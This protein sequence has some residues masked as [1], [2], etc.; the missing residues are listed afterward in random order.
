MNLHLMTILLA[1][2]CY[3]GLIYIVLH[4]G[5]RGNRLNQVFSLYLLTMVL[6]H[7]AYLMVDI[8]DSVEG[9]LFWYKVVA[10]VVSGQ[11]IVYFIFT[12]TLLRIEV[13]S[14]LVQ[15]GLLV[16]ALTVI[17][18]AVL[19]EPAF[20][21]GIHRDEAT[22]FFVPTFGPLMPILG[23]PNY[24][25]LGYAIFKLI[26]G[27][28]GTR[29][30]IQRS[31]IQYLLLGIMVVVLGI[32]ANFVPS[33]QPYPIDVVA[34][35][36]NAL[37]ITYAI[38]RYQLLDI[39]VVVRRGLLYSIPTAIIGAGYFLIISFTIGLFHAF[40]GPQILLVSFLVAVIAAVVV[41]P[42]RDR[43]QLWIDRIFFREKYDS[44][45][46]LQRLSRTAASLLDLD[47]L[48]TMILDEVTTTMHI[49]TAAFFLKRE[50]TGEF[51]LM[52]QRGLDQ[53]AGLRLKKGHPIVD[54][55][56]GHESAL[57]RHDME[58]MPQ[59]KALWGE[60]REDLERMGAELFIPL[61]AKDELV[62][63][64]TMG[65]KLSEAA[66]SKDDQ[67]ILTTLANQA[68]VAIENAR[69]YDVAQR[70]LAER[71][72]A[73]EALQEYTEQLEEMVEQRTLE[74]RKTYS[75][76]RDSQTRLIQSEKLA[77][78]GRLAASVA[79]EVNNPLQGISNYLAVISQ[80]VSKD[81]PL[82]EDLDMVKLGFERITEIVRRLR[83]F[84][85]P[86]GEGMEPTD[87]N[88]A[89]ERVLAL[90]SHQ[91]SLGQVEV[92]TELAEQ[93]LLVLGSAGQL[94]QVLVNLALNAQ[95][96]MPQGGELMVRTTRRDDVVQ[97]QVTDTGQGIG[98]EEMSR[99]FKPFYSGRGGK[100]LGLGLWISHNI[101]EGHG[102]HIEVESQV[103]QGTTFTISLPVYQRER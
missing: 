46:M 28:R 93:E 45:L 27:Y 62:G 58:M 26:Q 94:E 80:Q 33:L 95:E 72:R 90:V 75:D 102:G 51:R 82:H 13:P 57:T 23:A 9:A 87:L 69:L 63:I 29:S 3:G 24:F 40:A 31:R 60:E 52:A 4:R 37:L 35:I 64:L 59:F 7:I 74:L 49:E 6:W 53:N 50:E 8:S 36:I 5:L 54:W 34:N 76:L 83:A 103:G 73:E 25:F 2:L 38:F 17:L 41:Q 11:F 18:V 97:L 39:T 19:K 78:T 16:W 55:L 15:G 22:G 56:S 67:L 14:R 84:Y 71:V 68:A 10:A 65:P 99:L 96:S 48:T 81:D 21:T 43:A 47:R 12:K 61:E 98:E 44:S 70:E 92:K 91:L 20:F 85:R 89:V 30:D 88:G 79:H 100:G 86:V 101:I 77:A 1:L 66:Y 32:M 42:L